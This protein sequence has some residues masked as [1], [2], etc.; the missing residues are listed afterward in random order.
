MAIPRKGS[1]PITV[2]GVAY[3]WMVRHKPSY[4]QGIIESSLTVAVEHDDVSGSVL[5]LR[6][7]QAHPSNWMGA[8]AV[9][10]RPAHVAL[11]IRTAL[12]QGWKPERPGHPFRL[13]LTPPG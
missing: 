2:D 4:S 13:N 11:G 12:G 5:A 9:A 6:L 1:R 7:P 10:V 3:R 8:P